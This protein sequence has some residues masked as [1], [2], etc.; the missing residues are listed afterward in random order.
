M[1]ALIDCNNF[2]ASCERV[3][4]PL[5]QEQPVVVLSNNDGCVIARSN[6]AKELGV[7]MGAPAFEY[8]HLFRKHGVK[9]FS[10]NFPLYG[11]MSRRVMSILSKY[12]PNQEVYSIDECFLN[13]DGIT[14]NLEQYGLRMRAEVGKG[15]GIPISVGI[16]PTKSLSKVANRVAK[17]YPKQTGGSYLINSEEKWLKALKWLKV[18]DIWGIGRRNAN[19]LYAVGAFKAI[20]FINLPESW[21]LKNMTITGLNLQKDL[22]GIPTIK[23]IPGEKKKSIATTRTFETGLRAFDEVRERITT[24]TVMS[25]EKLREEQSLCKRLVVFLETNRFVEAE[26]HYYPSVLVKLPFPTN[27][28]LELVR[29]AMDGL[30][31]IYR[32]NTSFKRGGV[33]LMDFEDANQ[34][35]KSLFFNSNPKHKSLME[36]VDRLN[37]RYHKEV[38]RLASQDAKKHK[39]RQEYLSKQYTTDINDIITVEL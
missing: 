39:M 22:K 33:M 11:D 8:E 26:A 4:N 20:D 12:S 3:F 10:A 29:F 6:E 15:V 27:S 21:V 34:Y 5:L 24:F 9:V 7:P 36:V 23:L 17:K 37:R 14:G 16:A 31:Q 1:Y 13:L 25:S 19:K 28:T 30:K 18:E 35:Q 32:K 2:Y 38:I